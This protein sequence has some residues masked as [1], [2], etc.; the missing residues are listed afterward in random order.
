[1]VE[2]GVSRLLRAVAAA[3]LR[4]NNQLIVCTSKWVLNVL[5]IMAFVPSYGLWLWI[6]YWLVADSV[7]GKVVWRS[8]GDTV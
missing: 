2:Y 6:T 8:K 3:E 5:Y 4:H 1:M 7:R